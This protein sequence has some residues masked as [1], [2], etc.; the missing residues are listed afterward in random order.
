LSKKKKSSGILK[1]SKN[2][3]EV[4]VARDFITQA[5]NR[6]N[7]EKS[8]A[9]SAKKSDSSSESSKHSSERAEEPGQD[10]TGE[11]SVI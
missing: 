6:K 4:D 3:N 8:A 11:V 9:V 5:F 10:G 2:V 1:N 7:S